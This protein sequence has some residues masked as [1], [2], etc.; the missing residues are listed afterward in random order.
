MSNLMTNEWYLDSGR[1]FGPSSLQSQMKGRGAISSA[2]QDRWEKSMTFPSFLRQ[3]RPG[4][5]LFVSARHSPVYSS[6]VFGLDLKY[7]NLWPFSAPIFSHCSIFW[8][9]QCKYNCTC[10]TVIPTFLGVAKF[11]LRV[12]PLWKPQMAKK[13]ICKTANLLGFQPILC[14]QLWAV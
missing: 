8:Q 13:N 7:L 3:L 4:T 6:L 11:A 12:H 1:D 9:A 10:L 5:T 14:K 2:V